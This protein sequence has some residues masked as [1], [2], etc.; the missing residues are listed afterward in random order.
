MNK[1]SYETIQ[2]NKNSI[3]DGTLNIGDKVSS[4]ID[5]VSQDRNNQIKSGNTYEVVKFLPSQYAGGFIIDFNGQEWGFWF[6]N[7]GMGEHFQKVVTSKDD[8]VG[9]KYGELPHMVALV[10][11]Y[12]KMLS[13]KDLL[14]KVVNERMNVAPEN[15]KAVKSEI[16]NAIHYLKGKGYVATLSGLGSATQPML[17]ITDKGRKFIEEGIVK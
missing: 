15:V 17:S 2:L 6:G 5:I 9:E 10:L 14:N 3:K 4:D 8:E 1:S 7:N 12:N 11:Y 16:L 13:L